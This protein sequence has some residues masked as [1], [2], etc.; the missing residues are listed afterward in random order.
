MHAAFPA[1]H[2]FARAPI[3]VIDFEGNDLT[4]TQSE[5]SEENQGRIVASP[6][7]CR[8]LAAIEQASDLL[9]GQELQIS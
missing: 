6:C 2:H 7:R 5:T 4:G 9:L 1:N 8:A 3:N